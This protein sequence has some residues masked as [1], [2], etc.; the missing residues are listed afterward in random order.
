MP[1]TSRKHVGRHQDGLLWLT[2]PSCSHEFSMPEG[3]AAN[4]LEVR[5]EQ[6]GAPAWLE[7][8]HEEDGSGAHWS[9]EPEQ[10]WEED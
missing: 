10:Y 8:V 3:Q 7:R 6:C 2:C 4:G 5:C 1:E 9:L